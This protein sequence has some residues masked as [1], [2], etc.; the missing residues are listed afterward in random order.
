MGDLE[1]QKG[2]NKSTVYG[3]LDTSNRNPE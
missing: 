1:K 2:E 3:S